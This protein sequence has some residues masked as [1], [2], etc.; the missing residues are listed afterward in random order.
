MREDTI[1]KLRI[2][3]LPAVTGGIGCIT[4]KSYTAQV[5][6]MLL[7]VTGITQRRHMEAL[8]GK[9]CYLLDIAYPMTNID[10]GKWQNTKYAFA[11]K[12]IIILQRE[13]KES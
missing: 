7:I 11:G 3:F 6:K 8:Q 12:E 2:L 10:L 13:D 9:E 1:F 5:P 4:K